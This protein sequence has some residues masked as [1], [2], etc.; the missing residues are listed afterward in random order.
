MECITI[1]QGINCQFMVKTGCCF[2]GGQCHP[3]VEKCEG[4]AHIQDLPSGRFCDSYAH[5]AIKW[6]Y[7]TCNFATHIQPE[8]KQE[9]KKLNPLKAS[10]RGIR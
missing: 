2:N 1:K 8:Q 10:K 7:G 3:I 4:C 9:A 6:M 5:P